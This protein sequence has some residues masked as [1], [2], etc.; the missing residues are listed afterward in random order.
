MMVLKIYNFCPRDREIAKIMRRMRSINKRNGFRLISFFEIAEKKTRD[1]NTDC[2]CVR[3]CR[4]D[5]LI[6]DLTSILTYGPE[7]AK[8]E[9]ENFSDGI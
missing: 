2:G 3:Y 8:S 7:E 9:K 6:S 5:C 4:D 1:G